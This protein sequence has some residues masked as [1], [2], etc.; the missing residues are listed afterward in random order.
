MI[1]QRSSDNQLMVWLANNT[2]VAMTNLPSLSLSK[3]V[4]AW[5]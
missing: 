4:S 1:L 3:Q 5:R 2:H